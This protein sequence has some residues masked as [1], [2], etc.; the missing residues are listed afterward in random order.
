VKFR[1]CAN[2]AANSAAMC[3][4]RNA[5]IKQTVD[6]SETT[7]ENVAR[8]SYVPILISPLASCRAFPAKRA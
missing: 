4:H 8:S 5:A 3:R 7:L 2:S 1:F 6:D